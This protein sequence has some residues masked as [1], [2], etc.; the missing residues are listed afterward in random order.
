MADEDLFIPFEPSA[1]AGTVSVGRSSVPTPGEGETLITPEGIVEGAPGTSPVIPEQEQVQAPEPIDAMEFFSRTVPVQETAITRNMQNAWWDRFAREFQKQRFTT[2]DD[3]VDYVTT[4]KDENGTNL[5]FEEIL[6]FIQKQAMEYMPPA[7]KNEF[8]S[9]VQMKAEDAQFDRTLQRLDRLN[10]DPENKRRGVSYVLGKTGN[11]E[12]K[13]TDPNKD[14]DRKQKM[15]DGLN[16]R[17]ETFDKLK[18][19]VSDF[20]LGEMDA[21][22]IKQAKRD[23]DYIREMDEWRRERSIL[24]GQLDE[25]LGLSAD[26]DAATGMG[27]PGAASAPDAITA[28]NPATGERIESLDGGKTW[29]PVQ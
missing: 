10:A 21:K 8:Q 18:P 28:T 20:V 11:I 14:F 17:L 5:A 9:K 2:L 3:Y 15:V 22:G 12:A 16:K 13:T 19:K 27:E 23:P 25:A 7:L 1:G 4:L 29:Q 6:P 24:I 26:E